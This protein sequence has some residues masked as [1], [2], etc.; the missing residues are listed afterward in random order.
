MARPMMI[1]L[2]VLCAGTLFVACGDDN[3]DDA[4]PAAVGGTSVAA[5]PTDP[6]ATEPDTTEPATTSAPTTDASTTDP[7]GNGDIEAACAAYTE[8]TFAF[9]AEPEGDPSE[10][11]Q[12]TVVPLIETIEANAPAEVS[13][14][15]GVMTSAAQQVVDSGGEDFSAFEDPAFAEAQSEV[16]PFMFENCTYD[17][18]YEVSLV[19][20]AFADMP[21]EIESG[22]VAILVTNDGSEAHELAV[23]SKAEGVTESWE[24]LLQLPEEE[25]MTKATFVGGAFAPAPGSQGMLVVDIEPGDYAAVCFVSTGTTI[26]DSGMTEGTGPPHFIQGMFSEFTV[27]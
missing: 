2:L 7:A 27:T 1:P 18:T 16:D 10:F 20:Y 19:D 3:D 4:S 11:L 25:A 22:R 17:S 24:E 5:S 23:L 14:S 12:N 13:D 26:D 15:L 6:V 9:S 8:L 21:S